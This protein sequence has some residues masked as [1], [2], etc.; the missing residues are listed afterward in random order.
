[1]SERPATDYIR[2]SISKGVYH[3]HKRVL[4]VQRD[5]RKQATGKRLTTYNQYQK[6]GGKNWQSFKQNSSS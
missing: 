6:S 4:E 2:N 3:Q 1:M 5:Y